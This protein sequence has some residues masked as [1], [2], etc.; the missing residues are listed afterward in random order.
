MV[1]RNTTADVGCYIFFLVF[2]TLELVNLI[3]C[4][5]TALQLAPTLEGK[6]ATHWTVVY[7][8]LGSD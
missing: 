1:P 2:V 6:N 7:H 5:G 8:P 3:L 4:T